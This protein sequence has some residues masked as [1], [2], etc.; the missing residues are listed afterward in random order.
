MN[1]ENISLKSF[2]EKSLL[3]CVLLHQFV[4]I[5]LIEPSANVQRQLQLIIFNT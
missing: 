1:Y 2:T 5:C 3:K 4:P